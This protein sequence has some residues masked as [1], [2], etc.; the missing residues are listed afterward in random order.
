MVNKRFFLEKLLKRFVSNRKPFTW[1]HSFREVRIEKMKIFKKLFTLSRCTLSINR[2]STG[3]HVHATCFL[4]LFASDMILLLQNGSISD[5]QCEIFSIEALSSKFTIFSLFLLLIYRYLQQKLFEQ[6]LSANTTVCLPTG[7]G[8][9]FIAIRLMIA[10]LEETVGRFPESAK[11]MFFLTPT[12][13]LCQQQ[14]N[15]IKKYVTASVIFLTG[16]QGVDDFTAAQ[17][18]SCLKNYQI[19]VM[20]P[21]IMHCNVLIYKPFVRILTISFLAVL[22]K[23][24]IHFDNINLIVFDEAHWALKKGRKQSHHPYRKIMCMYDQQKIMGDDSCRILG[25]SASLINSHDDMKQLSLSISHIEAIYHSTVCSGVFHLHYKE[26]EVFLVKYAGSPLVSQIETESCE[27]PLYIDSILSNRQICKKASKSIISSF[28]KFFT[29]VSTMGPWC[30][31]QLLELIKRSHQ[32]PTVIVDLC[33]YLKNR[34]ASVYGISEMD[35]PNFLM[36]DVSPKLK[37]LLKILVERKDNVNG[38]IF[39]KERIIANLLFLWLQSLS[40]TCRT[41]NFLMPAFI[42]G[43]NKGGNHIFSFDPSIKN[44]HQQ[45][46][47][48]KF[49]ILVA[50][51]VMEEGIDV[52]LFN[53]VIRYDFPENFRVYCQ[54]RG[55]ARDIN[56]H[57]VLM[58]NMDSLAKDSCLLSKYRECDNKL[59]Q[60]SSRNQNID[61][62]DDILYG[63]QCTALADFF[64]EDPI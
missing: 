31:K 37:A 32:Q 49:N 33:R 30:A 41:F 2:P 60:L 29:I 11:R 27:F 50:T 51:S 40:N 18:M 35:S 48:K 45:F 43:Q 19:V 7:T 24:I 58:M 17:W 9:T 1:F 6:A 34:I 10:K 14:S 16:D 56:S 22:E 5:K 21:S 13:I 20:T 3:E 44:I 36:H 28:K 25:L 63:S 8:K 54:S 59:K 15:V 55:R 61:V 39:V 47:E 4:Q 53:T 46:N 12:R 62:I 38:I 26:A 42:M 64:Q 52:P 23:R 57:F